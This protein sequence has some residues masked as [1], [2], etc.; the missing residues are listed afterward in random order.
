MRLL[1]KPAK[2]IL[3]LLKELPTCPLNFKSN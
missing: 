2:D 1:K 3:T